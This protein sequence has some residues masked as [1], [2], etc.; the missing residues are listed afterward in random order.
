V[1]WHIFS[2]HHRAFDLGLVGLTLFVPTALFAFVAGPVV[3]RTP[4]TVILIV[5]TLA[6]LAGAIGLIA[7]V[8]AHVATL[9]PY[10]AVLFGIGT[11]RAFGAPAERGLL[12]SIV[13][14][15]RYIRASASYGSVRELIGMAGPAAGGALVAIGTPIA[16]GVAALVQAIAL[17]GILGLRLPAIAPRSG[18]WTL[19]DALGGLRFIRSQPVILGAI[20]LDLFAVLFGGAVSLLP[21]FADTILR[22]GPAGLGILRAAPAVGSFTSAAWL[23]RRPP[24]RHV[25]MTLLTAVALFGAATIVFAL[26][27]NLYVSLAALALTGAADMVSVVIRSGLVQLNTP[28]VVRGRVTAVENVFIGASNELGAFESGTA[29]ALLGLVPS[30][31]VGGIATLAVVAFAATALP[32]L[33]RADTLRSSAT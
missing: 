6:E 25:G 10:L 33:R 11:A 31:I 15:E 20:T 19:D 5:A 27:H 12:L 4:R 2:L 23:S 1:G 16:L 30:V 7:L 29:A 18:A 28:D 32:A 26:S 22:V 13:P 24:S 21:A 17:A 14:P 3:D 8:V 9:A